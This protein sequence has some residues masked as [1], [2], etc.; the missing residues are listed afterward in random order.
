MPFTTNSKDLKA[1][2]AVRRGNKQDCELPT[3]QRNLVTS[4]GVF[5]QF[6][7]YLLQAMLRES[8]VEL[9]NNFVVEVY[10]K[11][12]RDGKRAREYL[13]PEIAKL[14]SRD[15]HN[16]GNITPRNAYRQIP[17]RYIHR[18]PVEHCPGCSNTF[19]F[20]KRASWRCGIVLL[21]CAHFVAFS[22][23][24][25]I[26]LNRTIQKR[27]PLNVVCLSGPNTHFRNAQIYMPLQLDSA[28]PRRTP[29]TPRNASES[30]L[31]TP[32]HPSRPKISLNRS[33]FGEIKQLAPLPPLTLY[34]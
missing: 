1:I 21:E 17:P 15:G 33:R 14:R 9:P 29:S 18:L 23:V 28:R 25:K 6:R 11:G 19:R 16:D 24:R 5:Q 7:D 8:S 20:T 13:L 34:P 27:G 22:P 3:G 32:C 10:V 30:G 12:G 26:I 4:S 2:G 31:S